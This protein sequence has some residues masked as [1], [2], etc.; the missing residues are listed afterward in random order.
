MARPSK[1]TD[2]Q[3]EKI[4]SR[5]LAG[6]SAASLSREFKV[7]K[8]V[9]SERF[10]KRKEAVKATANLI[11]EADNA[12]SLL[13][14][15]EQ[16]AAFSFANELKLISTH[17]AGSAKFGAINSHRLSGIANMQL[18]KIDENELHDPDSMS[19]QVVK[20][21]SALTDVANRSAQTGINLLNANKAQM[22][23]M[24]E[25]QSEDIDTLLKLVG[26]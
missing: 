4:G 3:W 24:A 1:L 13:N 19:V 9:I 20:V 22:E 5:L 11:I 17:L 12:L 18:D 8:A 26:G 6:E 16:K 7:S 21:I 10:S 25:S 23:K 15:N 2:V 14:I